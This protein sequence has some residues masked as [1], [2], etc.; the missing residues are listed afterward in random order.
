[1]WEAFAARI[2][3]LGGSVLLNARVTA[4]SHDGHT[5]RGVEIEDADGGRLF[6]PASNVVSTMPLTH[7][8]RSLG[9][10][11]PAAVQQATRHLKYRD[12][13]TVAV[14]VDRAELFP[15][16]WIYIHD[17]SVKVGRIQNFKNWSA[18]MVPDRSK[19][20]LGLEYFCSASDDIASLSNTQLVELATSEL[21]AIGLVERQW[22]VDATVV[23]VPEAY[24]VYDEDYEQ[25]LRTIREYVS[26][27][28]NLQTIGRNGTHTYNNQD[29]SMVMGMLAVRNLF[30]DQHDVWTIDHPDEYLEELH[31][32]TTPS[33][34]IGGRSLASTQPLIPTLVRAREAF[35]PR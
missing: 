35:E 21:E 27:F 23:R 3:G 32:A 26:G 34:R 16:N 22:I 2:E 29:H 7:L 25:A 19:T 13:I 8:V 10:S 30:G 24:P 20:C 9:R 6:Q 12:F 28:A 31:E 5:V 1:M 14:V 17:P 15:D 11:A 18:D 4:V 33:L